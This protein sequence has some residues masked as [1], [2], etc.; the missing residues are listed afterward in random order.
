MQRLY[1]ESLLSVLLRWDGLRSKI[2]KRRK[3][4]EAH[5]FMKIRPATKHRRIF[6]FSYQFSK[7]QWRRLLSDRLRRKECKQTLY[8]KRNQ[9]TTKSPQYSR[10]FSNILHLFCWGEKQIYGYPIFTKTPIWHFSL[11]CIK[12]HK[13]Q[14][15]WHLQH[16]TT[17]KKKKKNTIPR[18]VEVKP[19]V[20]KCC[21]S[22]SPNCFRPSGAVF[23]S[24]TGE[25]VAVSD[26]KFT[27][28]DSTCGCPLH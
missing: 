23:C 13:N 7:Y 15:Q 16:W 19:H 8:M 28:A 21:A 12:L 24:G 5:N 3:T 4:N 10:T 25:T 20:V 6:K 26:V 9:M 27:W 17:T 2:L 18:R 1:N 22:S 14:I 11:Y